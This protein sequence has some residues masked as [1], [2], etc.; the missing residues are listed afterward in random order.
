MI[1]VNSGR[2]PYDQKPTMAKKESSA[3]TVKYED[4]A[5]QI[6]Q[7]QFAPVYLL[8]GEEPFF[9]DRLAKMFEDG[10]LE[11]EERDFNQVVLYGKDTEVDMV[12]ANAKQFP[13]GSPYRVVILK[14]AKDLKGIDKLEA[15]LENPSPQTVL[16]ICHKYGKMKGAALK[17]CTKNGVV[18]DSAGVK[19]YNLRGWIM[20]L[21][22]KMFQYKLSPQTAELLSEHIGNDLSRIYT[23]FQKIQV[24]LPAGSEITPDTVE[25]YIGISKEYNIF[26]LQEALGRRNVQKAYSI[27]LNFTMHQKENPN[28]RTILMLFNFYNKMIRY[29]L[30]PEKNQ[31]S[32]RLLYGTTYDKII[33]T[34]VSYANNHSLPQLTRIVSILREYDVKSK[35]VDATKN[36]GE[37]LK[38]MIYKIIHA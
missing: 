5:A 22:T 30:L 1:R 37:L 28:I 35:G 32:L 18:F 27:M 17:A 6:Q 7:K 19:D 13:F 8:H 20:D 11:P 36:D 21:A 29:H 31:E 12:V 34:N 10:V 33:A 24:F 16:V 23:E 25:K 14:E 2:Q 38:E 9:I 15:Y 4:I 3:K 26:E